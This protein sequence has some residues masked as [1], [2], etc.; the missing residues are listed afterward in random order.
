MKW[1]AGTRMLACT[2]SSA[3]GPGRKVDMR[4]GQFWLVEDQ[5]TGPPNYSF[6]RRFVFLLPQF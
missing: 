4:R 3:A 1:H 5:K 2:R 6:A